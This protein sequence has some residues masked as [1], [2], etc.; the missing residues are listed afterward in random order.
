VR[1]RRTVAKED[2]EDSEERGKR[3]QGS[4]SRNDKTGWRET[5][6]TASGRRR[7]WP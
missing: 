4:E 1:E 6:I 2:Q 7:R 5:N 3:D